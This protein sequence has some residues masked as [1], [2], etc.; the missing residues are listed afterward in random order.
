VIRFAHG[1]ATDVGRVRSLNEDSFLVAESLF[2][3]ADGMGGHRGGE[4]ASAEALEALRTSVLEPDAA[5]LVGA[6]ESANRA[7]FEHS[8]TDPELS[9]MGTTICAVALVRDDEGTPTIAIVNVGDS[10]VYLL[11]PDGEFRQLTEDHS[12]VET[13]V[14]GGQLSPDEAAVHPGRNVLTR[15]LGIEPE[16]EVDLFHQPVRTGDRFLLCSDGLFN[17][18]HD[19]QI[20]AVLRRLDQPTD[21]ASELVRRATEAGGRDN[22][23]VVIVDVVEGDGVEEDRGLVGGAPAARPAPATDDPLGLTT[24]T[25]QH[26]T[27]AEEAA[28]DLPAAAPEPPP[29][30]PARPRI[31]WRVW[32]FVA[33]VIVVIGVAVGAVVASGD[34][35]T[36]TVPRTSTTPPPSTS[37]TSTTAP[38]ATTT[39]IAGA[40]PATAPTTATP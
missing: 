34:S 3:V 2:A 25:A 15:A 29:P 33:A 5:A 13:M 30:P 28:A 35:P 14:R 38:G 11:S 40:P 16:I 23:T 26:P 10:R 31:T 21:A 36:T 39:A 22:V 32:A 4:V 37:S 8:L 24:D 1:T 19:D 12:L 9:G 7:V 17:E 6:V 20:S 27:I 18:L